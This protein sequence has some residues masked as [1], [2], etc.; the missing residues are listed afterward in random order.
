MA[1]KK[2]KEINKNEGSKKVSAEYYQF[3]KVQ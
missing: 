1:I 2:N 3:S